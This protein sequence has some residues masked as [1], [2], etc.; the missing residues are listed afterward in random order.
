MT[1]GEPP[2]TPL[3]QGPPAPPNGDPVPRAVVNTFLESIGYDPAWVAGL[4]VGP[5]GLVVETVV[6]ELY[7]AVHTVRHPWAD[8]EPIPKPRTR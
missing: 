6:G 5:N 4:W 1:I 8:P 3:P 7:P 2:L